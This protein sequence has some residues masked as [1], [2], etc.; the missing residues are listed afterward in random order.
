M[1]LVGY[2]FCSRNNNYFQ[3]NEWHMRLSTNQMLKIYGVVF[4]IYSFLIACN[5]T[6]PMHCKSDA[7]CSAQ[8]YCYDNACF[9][10]QCASDT[11]CLG[12]R[13]CVNSMCTSVPQN[14]TARSGTLQIHLT[15][16]S[17]PK[18][19]SYKVYFKDSPGV[20]KNDQGL[21]VFEP[22][23]THSGLER[24][25]PKY[26]AVAAITSVGESSLSEEVW[27]RT[28]D[29]K[30]TVP[31]V[32]DKPIYS[33]VSSEDGTT[34]IA[35]AG[36]M[37]TGPSTGGGV[38]LDASSADKTSFPVVN[39]SVFAVADDNQGGWYIGGR[40]NYIN[41]VPRNN[42]AHILSNGSVDLE[43][44]PGAN[45]DVKAI[46][47][48]GSQ[49][50]RVVVG[51]SFSTVGGLTRNHLAAIFA[52][53]F[54]EEEYGRV[55]ENWKADANGDV[56]SIAVMNYFTSDSPDLCLGGEFTNINGLP[57]NHIAC[58]DI[59]GTLSA[60]WN[61]N[62]D[63]II[64]AVA[65]RDE[66]V[67]M[68]GDSFYGFTSHK[69]LISCLDR[70]TGTPK[71]T[72]DVTSRFNNPSVQALGIAQN[73]LYVGGF[74][75]D[76]GGQS[77][78][79]LAELDLSTGLATEWNPSP[80]R[81]DPYG[82]SAINISALL[83]SSDKKTIYVG[84][85]FG[86]YNEIA[87]QSRNGFASFDLTSGNILSWNPDANIV[88]SNSTFALASN[89]SN[90][91]Y[92]GGDF[93]SIGNREKRDIAAI[94]INGNVTPWGQNLPVSFPIAVNSQTIYS[95]DEAIDHK[96]IIAVDALTGI[97]KWHTLACRDSAMN[98][99]MVWITAVAASKNIVYFAG[100][101]EPKIVACLNAVDAATGQAILNWNVEINGGIDVISI[102]KKSVYLAGPFSLINGQDRNSIAAIDHLIGT[103]TDFAPATNGHI[104]SIV[105]N[106]TT[107]YLGG[108]FTEINNETR[109]Y[110]AAVDLSGNII[111]FAHQV[112]GTIYTM[113][114]SNG[115]LYIG[116]EFTEVDGQS[117]YSLAAIELS[118][119]QLTSWDPRAGSQCSDRK[120]CGTVHSISVAGDSVFVGGNFRTVGSRPLSYFAQIPKWKIR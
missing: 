84:G 117:R 11:D 10:S 53:R 111:P 28:A 65:S 119:D 74:F 42:I 91:I 64:R 59:D 110:L 41:D 98:T 51:G 4:F 27:S 81:W 52:Q 56:L 40:F 95:E 45:G 48:V 71:W 105:E 37:Q 93:S 113:V 100:S 20:T 7:D 14:I 3:N 26:Y 69:S 75:H 43:W 94:D 60:N 18:V 97:Q 38:I 30:P 2:N 35:G 1:F 99:D 101:D 92:I 47:I 89:Y 54:W 31:L 96:G 73:S 34:Y 50:T 106:E 76:I 58:L 61:A 19:T 32:A 118:K 44:D 70:K 23:Y 102:G 82:G 79:S 6:F 88:N 62:S 115:V 46:A 87:S 36:I 16:D 72:A 108:E 22:S 114:I 33:V 39:G 116:G 78:S 68:G 67:C 17:V 5:P 57:R 8:S 109:N 55:D 86:R 77:R 107:V 25:A 104:K 15:W 12:E 80:Y 63:V 21:E 120:K 85:G 29:E 13:G 112:N 9:R 49:P 66:L 83:L 24:W 103:L 90:E